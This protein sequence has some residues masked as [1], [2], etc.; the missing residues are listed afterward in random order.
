VNANAFV[1]IKGAP[2]APE[3]VDG[4]APKG[5]HE[6]ALGRDALD[7]VGKGIGDSVRV[8]GN[9]RSA[10]FRIVGQAVFPSLGDAVPLSDGATL[11]RRALL[12]LRAVSDGYLVF[13]LAPGVDRAAAIRH[14]TNTFGQGELPPI[15]PVVPAEV[16]RLRQVDFLV[17]VLGGFV[18]LVAVVAIGYTLVTAVRR[19]RRELAI[20]KTIGFDRAQVRAT[21]AWHSTT[22]AVVGLLLGIP[23]GIAAGRVLWGLVAGGLG[24]STS[25]EVPV[26]AIVAVVPAAILLTNLV[27]AFPGR[28]AARTSPA[29]VLRSE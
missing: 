9:G 15:A 27:A 10:V 20:L 1:G 3:I 24:V 13:R 26:W 5:L 19:R 22:L 6:I 17:P 8:Q 4:R 25:I 21:V 7:A 12:R 28:D 16:E 29:V 14:L 11:S 18:A 2:I 23:L